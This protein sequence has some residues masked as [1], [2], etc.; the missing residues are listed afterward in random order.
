MLTY[1]SCTLPLITDII[2]V[3][4]HMCISYEIVSRHGAEDIPQ[5]RNSGLS[6]AIKI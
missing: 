3:H 4:R 5:S 2:Y 1:D 6:S